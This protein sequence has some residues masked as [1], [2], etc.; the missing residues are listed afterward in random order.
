[1]TGAGDG[2]VGLTLKTRPRDLRDEA[3]F[4]NGATVETIAA[5]IASGMGEGDS[6]MPA[7]PHLSL[8][9]RTSIA[10]FIVSL[11]ATARQKPSEGVQP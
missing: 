2:P 10:R 8:I 3:A 7:Y 9:D 11:R 4:K 6:K 5:T 1:M